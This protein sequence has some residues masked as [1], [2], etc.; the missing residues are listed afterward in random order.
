MKTVLTIAGSDSSGGAGIQADLKTFQALGVY[1]TS[2]ITAVTVQNTQGVRAVHDIPVDV[3]AAQIDAVAE[4]IG[5][6]AVKTGMLSSA[7]IIATVVDRVR[8][9]RLYDRLVVDPVMVATSGARLLREDAVRTLIVD[10]LPLAA[11]L[12]PNLVEAAALTGRAVSTEAEMQDA[13]RALVQMG[14]RRVVM[15]GGHLRGEP[16]DLLLDG[17]TF[18]RFPAARVQTRSTHG[19]GCTFS[20]A[21]AAALAQGADVVDAVATA[22]AYLTG[23]LQHATPIGHGTGPVAH[24]WAI[25]R[26]AIGVALPVPVVAAGA[27]GHA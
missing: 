26:L 9:W 8:H 17:S 5:V 27:R 11:V 7:A 12:T 21:I 19:T 25:S 22:K 23:A 15:K 13:A 20:A 1:G 14:A 4:D 3:L 2:A 24:G 6:D 16:V 18:H 10:L